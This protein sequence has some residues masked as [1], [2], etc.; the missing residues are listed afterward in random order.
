MTAYTVLAF[1]SVLCHI[2]RVTQTLLNK[3]GI[4]TCLLSV[5]IRRLGLLFHA[6]SAG[7]VR[8]KKYVGN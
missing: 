6:T 3:P 5:L 8:T 1:K 4:C 2:L 7:A